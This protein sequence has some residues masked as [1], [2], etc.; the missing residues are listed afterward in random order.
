MHFMVLKLFCQNMCKK[1]NIMD[2]L[3]LGMSRMIYINML[4]IV[5][6]IIS[7]IV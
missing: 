3:Q 7:T 6:E 4:S 5:E 1:Y 2:K